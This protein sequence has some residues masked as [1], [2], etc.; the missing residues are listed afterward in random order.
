MKDVFAVCVGFAMALCFFT[1]MLSI[2][3]DDKNE[4]RVWFCLLAGALNALVY[5][6]MFRML[7]VLLQ[8]DQ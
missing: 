5:V 2:I 4:T 1:W 3:R 8:L 6:A 7:W